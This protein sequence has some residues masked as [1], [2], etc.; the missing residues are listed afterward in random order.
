MFL[1][2]E[3]LFPA[4]M[5]FDLLLGHFWVINSWTLSCSLWTCAFVLFLLDHGF[6]QS[7]VRIKIKLFFRAEV[8]DWR[9]YTVLWKEAKMIVCWEWEALGAFWALPEHSWWTRL[10]KGVLHVT[11]IHDILYNWSQWGLCQATETNAVLEI[12][13]SRTFEETFMPKNLKVPEEL[14]QF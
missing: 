5:I 6:H 9:Y 7:H 10:L 8:Y 3:A 2:D 4:S 12:S 13:S 1:G 14:M 11:C